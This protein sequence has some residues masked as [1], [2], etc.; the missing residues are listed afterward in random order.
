MRKLYVHIA[1]SLI[2][3]PELTFEMINFHT[4]IRVHSRKAAWGTL[5]NKRFQPSAVFDLD[6]CMD[7]KLDDMG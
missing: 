3:I 1:I 7:F 2:F 5:L 6:S 4:S